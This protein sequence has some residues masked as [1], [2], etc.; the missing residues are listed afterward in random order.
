MSK[1][2]NQRYIAALTSHPLLTKCVTG[3]TLAALNELIATVIA[4]DLKIA[5]VLNTK[6]K[7]PF[8]AKLPLFAL[9]SFFVST[10]INHYGLKVINHLFKAPLTTKKRIGQIL[11]VLLTASPLLN[12][13]FVSFVSL[14]N[15]KPQLQ[16]FSKDEF[17]RALT[18]VKAALKN[19]LFSV[20]KSSWV[21]TPI[22]LT[23]CQTYLEPEYWVVFSNLVYFVLGTGQN[24]FLKLNNAKNT[25]LQKR[26]EELKKEVSQ[27]T[28]GKEASVVPGSEDESVSVSAQ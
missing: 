7:H 21:T 4:K 10:P 8:S 3:A 5:N 22:V 2:L 27:E 23:I 28:E 26:Q 12:V 1:S 9:F 24:T 14:I 17:K 13:L 15:L 6:V 18:S 16:A 20:I 11:T 25:K 19:S